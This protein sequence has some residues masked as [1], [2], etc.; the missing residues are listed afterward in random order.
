MREPVTTESEHVRALRGERLP[1]LLLTASD[2]TRRDP[3]A[4]RTPFTVLYFFP[5]AYA[6][7]AAYPPGWAG[8]PGA[9]GCTRQSCSYRDQLALFTAAGATVHGISTQLPHEQRAFS[10]KEQLRFPLLSDADLALAGALGLPL[11]EA[12]GIT[13]LRRTTLVVARDRT[14]LETIPATTDVEEGVR[15][16]LTAVQARSGRPASC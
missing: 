1:E 2:G 3:V 16:A 4:D 13:R 5:G 15:S 7:A 9:K 14:I 6:D 10:A 12:G 11:F 8:L